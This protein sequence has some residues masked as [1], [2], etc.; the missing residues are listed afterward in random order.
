MLIFELTQL[1]NNID[2]EYNYIQL[3][4]N[5][6]RREAERHTIDYIALKH[7]RHGSF[8]DELGTIKAVEMP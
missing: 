3:V 6:E 5:H 7:I 1:Y 8:A 2:A 4:L